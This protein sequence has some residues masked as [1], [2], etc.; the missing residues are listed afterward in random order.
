MIPKTIIHHFEVFIFYWIFLLCNSCSAKFE[1][2][3]KVVLGPQ[4]QTVEERGLVKESIK[5]K[6]VVE[7]HGSYYSGQTVSNFTTLAYVTPWNNHGYDVAKL[8]GH[9]FSFISPVWLQLRRSPDTGGGGWSITGLHD[10][11]KGWMRDVK[12]NSGA[13]PTKI[14][15]RIIFEGWNNAQ[16]QVLVDDRN[17]RLHLASD[18]IS[19][20]KG[21]DG[22]V[23]EVWSQLPARA[24]LATMPA[25]LADLS[26]S[27]RDAGYVSIL[28]IPPALYQGD[29]PG[30]FQRAQFQA[31]APHFDFFS[32]MTYDYSS[33]QNPGP[34]SPLSWMQKCVELIEPDAASSNRKKILLGLNLYGLDHSVTGGNH[35]LGSQVVQILAEHKPKIKFDDRSVE[36][37]FEYKTKGGRR[38]VFYPTLFSLQRRLQLAA[39]LG[40]GLSLWEVGQGLDYFYDLM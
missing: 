21:F 2:K 10:V 11:D 14:V 8:Q 23:L 34:N 19:A 7:N 28:V 32:L 38:T 35:V 12:K 6:E 4:P 13:K 37:F 9:R 17:L 20:I 31:L 16:F 5:W 18:L 30:I 3:N 15:P 26:S 39:A 29:A 25:V 33:F 27:I 40:T 22:L 24:L 1:S 36:H